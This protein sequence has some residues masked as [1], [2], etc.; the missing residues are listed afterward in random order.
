MLLPVP[1]VG[2]DLG[3]QYATDVNNCL[4]ILDAHDHTPGLGVQITPAG[5]NINTDLTIQN[6]NLTVIRSARLSAQTTPISGASDLNC[7][8]DTLGDLYFN[9]G[10]GNQIR[11]TQ[12]GGVAGTPGSIT[13]MTGGANV[14]YV[15][16]TQ[17]FVFQSA[18]NTPANLDGGALTLRNITANSNGVT[19]SPPSAMGTNYGLTLPTLPNAQKFMTLDA[20][21]N[22]SAPW[23]VDNNTIAIVSNQLAVQVPNLQIYM[24]H[25]FEAN[26]NYSGAVMPQTTVDG[27]MFFNFNATILAV[28]V[29]NLTSGSSGITELDLKVASPG[30]SFT[31]ILSTTAKIT[32]AASSNVW[33][34]SNSVVGAQTGI[35]KPTVGTASITAGQALRFDIIQTMAGAADCGVIVQYIPR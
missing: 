8:Y 3:P 19:L 25:Q 26:G 27:L 35:T 2:I 22:M 29:Y 7:I 16:A 24:Q 5:L 1:A 4:T 23:T 15:P 32:S 30:G 20:A 10:V 12:N 34:D 9:D 33:T 17:T 13:G 11:I 28:W 21:G 14:A 31:S 18:A 6:N